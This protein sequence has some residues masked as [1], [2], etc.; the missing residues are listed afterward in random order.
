MGMSS[1]RNSSSDVTMV[2]RVLDEH[3]HQHPSVSQH[4]RETIALR[5]WEAFQNGVGNKEGL[6]ALLRA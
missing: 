6:R 4:D 1:V 3:F 2:G 5:L